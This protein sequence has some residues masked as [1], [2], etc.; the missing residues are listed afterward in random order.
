MQETVVDCA[1]RGFVRVSPMDVASPLATLHFPD[2][3]PPL[4]YGGL[5]Q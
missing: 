4:K 3:Y 1:L 5:F 2:F